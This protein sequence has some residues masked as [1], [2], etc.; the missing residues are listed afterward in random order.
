MLNIDNA[1]PYLLERGLVTVGSIVEGDLSIVSVARRNRNL[2]VERG[3]GPG[4]L[5]KQ[6]DGPSSGAQHTL[7]REAAFFDLCQREAS[8][9]EIRGI[10]PRL[11][12]FDP[13]GPLL[14][15]ELLEKPA[16]L[17]DHYSASEA[18]RFPVAT[19]RAAGRSLGTV[20]HV[21]RPFAG[22]DDPRLGFLAQGTPWVLRVHKPGPE[23]LSSLSQANYQTLRIL[24]TQEGLSQ[25]L[26]RVGRLWKAETVIHG[27]IKS[28]N[29]L[30]L[31][32]AD[33][34]SVEPPVRLVD[35]ELVQTGDPAWDVAGA[36]QD[37]ILFWV[38]SMPLGGG[39]EPERMV[40]EAR[41]PLAVLQPAMRAF[42]RG[43]RTGAGLGPEEG[44]AV[45]G[46][47][48]AFSAARLIQSAYELAHDAAALPPYSALLLQISA[49]LLR[50]L[51]AGQVE[52]YGLLQEL[53]AA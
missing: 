3:D 46:R 49:N 33:A 52:L 17:W 11:L 25:S 28:D 4:Y 20:H 41:Y 16:N 30:V 34:E 21:L 26:D 2:R 12:Y 48:V 7:W 45:L 51:E 10:V 27:D 19:A 44:N 6:P 14:A 5:I 47:A 22:T 37:F 36:L 9:G 53:P 32:P 50:D 38:F 15:F 1:V 35:W 39:V 8:L 31:P 23:L 40:Q 43:Y 42:W 18:Q 29:V 24:Q 13:Q